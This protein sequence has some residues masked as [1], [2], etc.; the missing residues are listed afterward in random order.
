MSDPKTTARIRIPGYR[1]ER[2]IGRGGIATVYLAVQ[3]SLDREVALKVM[4]PV[5]VAE[6][7]FTERFIGEGRMVAQLNHPNIVTIFD[8]G[9]ENY[10]TYI[11]MEYLSG[12]S[13][14]EKLRG[15]IPENTVLGIVRQVAN[16]LA[17][18]H[19]SDIVHRDVK[20]ENIM[21]RENGVPV[22]TDF[23]I[24]KTIGSDAQLT[25]T[26]IIVG[27]PRYISP[28]QAEGRG[29]DARSD[30]Y[31]LG[32]ILYEMLAGQPPFGTSDSIALLYAHINDPIPDLPEEHRHLQ[33][34]VNATM[35]KDPD[36]RVSDCHKLSDMIYVI[37]R[38]VRRGNKGAVSAVRRADADNIPNA[39]GVPAPPAGPAPRMRLRPFIVGGVGVL[40]VALVLAAGL[41]TL[42]TPQSKSEVA[43][44]SVPESTSVGLAQAESAQQ[45][46]KAGAAPASGTASSPENALRMQLDTKV[47]NVA[48]RGSESRQLS[49][50]SPGSRES[51]TAAESTMQSSPIDVSKTDGAQDPPTALLPRSIVP[52]NDDQAALPTWKMT[53]PGSRSRPPSR[54]QALLSLAESQMARGHVDDPAG[55][56]AVETYRQ[57]LRI[58]ADQPQALTELDA[59]ARYFLDKSREA[60]EAKRYQDAQVMIERGLRAV[61]KHSVL[62]TYQDTVSSL[63]TADTEFANAEKYYWG[64]GIQRD[65]ALAAEWYRKAADKGHVQAQYSLGVAY[66]DG[67]GVPRD[68]VEGLRWLRRAAIQG[69]E[70]AQ[71]NLSLGLIFG[72]NPDPDGASQWV[73]LLAE[74]NYE[75]AFQVLGW[76]YSTGTGVK[77]SIKESIRWNVK[78]V[79]ADAPAESPSPERVVELW[80]RQ[81]QIAL[82]Q[83][84]LDQQPPEPH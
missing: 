47:A 8:I 73:K 5:L 75:P 79:M 78:H 84:R 10:H 63:L 77:L 28:E 57:V 46:S 37:L 74:K 39:A 72:P 58:A 68:E 52:A 66:A 71:F 27:T 53:K 81:L 19:D 33:P 54:L 23:G 48:Q 51:L 11:A 20:P 45:R 22:L 34:L 4:S 3:E 36:Q 41:R 82:A 62:L 12:G 43:D 42:S 76:M 67:A 9:A 59:I 21:F 31:S 24:A 83:T 26:G 30:L 56:N 7:N 70:D 16:A 15:A 14:R 2:E 6:S 18:A 40:L 69:V 61:P 35:A 17:C 49:E 44:V 38:E 32:V 64:Q 25:R 50:S 13:L 80:N 60:A 65:L 1:I 29:T 55:D